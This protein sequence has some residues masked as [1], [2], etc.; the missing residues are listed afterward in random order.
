MCM[1]VRDCIGAGIVLNVFRESG[2]WLLEDSYVGAIVR[3]ND[4]ADDGVFERKGFVGKHI[5]EDAAGIA[6]GEGRV[7]DY[8]RPA[9]RARSDASRI[10]GGGSRVLLE[11]AVKQT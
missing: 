7:A 8:P 2:G 11:V 5:A 6:D 9:T 10:P 3:N 4:I 1:S